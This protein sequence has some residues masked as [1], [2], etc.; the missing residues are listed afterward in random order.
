[1]YAQ[2]IAFSLVPMQGA[3]ENKEVINQVIMPCGYIN[4]F[5]LM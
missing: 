3:W 1:M 5:E 2:R 4:T